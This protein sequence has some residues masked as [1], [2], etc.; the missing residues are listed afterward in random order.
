MDG[1]GRDTD[2]LGAAG[3]IGAWIGAGVGFFVLIGDFVGRDVV[4]LFDCCATDIKAE[5]RAQRISTADLND[6][7]HE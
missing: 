6:L 1:V 4:A 5:L 7:Q 3:C 2:G